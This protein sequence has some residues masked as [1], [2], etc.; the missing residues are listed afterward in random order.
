MKVDFIV[1]QVEDYQIMLKLSY[2]ALAF[3]SYTA[4]LKNKRI[5]ELVSL[6]HSLHDF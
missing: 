6:S 3:K 2:R 1:C 5:L 4:S